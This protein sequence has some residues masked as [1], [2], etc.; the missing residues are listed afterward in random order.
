MPS[1]AVKGPAIADIA[2]KSGLAISPGANGSIMMWIPGIDFVGSGDVASMIGKCRE[3]GIDVLLHFDVIVKETRGEPQYDARC[4][5]I[6]CAVGENIAVSKSINKRDVLIS[7]RKR[8]NAAVVA[9]L[10]QPVF[11]G[12]DAKAGAMAMPPLQPQHAVARIDSL[13][14]KPDVTLP[15]NLAELVMFHHKR[16]ID[17]DQFEQVMFFAAGENGLKLIH[18][19]PEERAELANTLVERQLGAQ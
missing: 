16:L 19:A 15:E 4:R 2:E 14:A 5:L 10:M 8:G 1:L 12:L 7:A 11:D 13:L 9:E 17:D 18:G 6:N 3:N